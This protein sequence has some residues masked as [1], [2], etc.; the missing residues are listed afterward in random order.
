VKKHPILL[1]P[2]GD[3]GGGGQGDEGGE[4]RKDQTFQE[5]GDGGEG[6]DEGEGKTKLAPST[7]LTKDD[8]TDILSRV[9]PAGGAPE[10][11]Q[12]EKQYTPE[13][14]EKILNVWKPDA[15]FLKK[16]GFAEPTAEQLAAIHEMR[17][18]LVR[19]ANTM[20]EARIQQLLTEREAE[21]QELRSYVSEQR[22]EA[23]TKAFYTAN[24]ELEQYEEVVEAVSAKLESQG[25]KAPTQTKVF[26]EIA[27]NTHE[28]LKRMNVKVDKTKPAKPAGT[29]MASLAGGGQGGGEKG[30]TKGRDGKL[31]DM[32]IFDED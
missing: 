2:E 8:I 9:I 1:S 24:P 16:M 26:E 29:R 17:D 3:A 15:S 11:K 31:K 7:G 30:D 4:E 23:T 21:I 13:E 6:E 5:D 25:F 20:S 14:I 12:P 22:A 19:Q 18:A 27:K 10:T 28:V 32:S